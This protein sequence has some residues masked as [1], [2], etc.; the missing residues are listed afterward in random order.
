MIS[1][2][3]TARMCLLSTMAFIFLS[4]RPCIADEARSRPLRLPGLSILRADEGVPQPHGESRPVAKLVPHQSLAVPQQSQ[5]AD[6]PNVPMVTA[7]G[8]DMTR[9]VPG[10]TVGGFD[11]EG[12][13]ALG[14][15]LVK[16]S[17]VVTYSY[18]S[19]VQALSSN[20]RPDTA[21]VVSP[22]IEAFIPITRNGIRLDYSMLYR[23]YRNLNIS[24]N[25]DHTFNADSQFDLS[26]IVSLAVRDHFSMSSIDA[27]EFV[28]GREIVFSDS[29]FKRNEVSAQLLWSL[30]ENDSLAFTSTWNRV[31]FKEA[32]QHAEVPFYDYN[33]MSYA[34]TY[35]R[36]LSERFAVFGNGSYH[37]NSTDDPRNLADSRGFA[38]EGGIDG[39]LSPLVTGQ[40]SIGMQRDS[41]P[42]A[43]LANATALIFKGALA[44]EITERSQVSLS[45]SRTSNLSYFQQNAYFTSTGIVAAYGRELGRR[46]VTSLSASYQRN[47]YPMPLESGAGIP[48]ELVGR[49]SRG[50]SFVDFDFSLRYR[51]NDWLAMDARFGV[52]HRNSNVPEE[53][54]NCYRAGINFLIGNRGAST[55]RSPY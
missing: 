4:L 51:V 52:S 6:R 10:S 30:S 1:M 40:L 19:N 44:K 13:F 54:F 38:V 5:Q 50:D 25:F 24:Q 7:P 45:L 27:R 8:S 18:E 17:A 37:R 39:S 29:P 2:R 9:L 55:G 35:K 53:Q 26:P 49:T 23:D 14:S 11:Q 28:P 36:D 33:Q 42:G 48:V 16:P 20:Y 41:Y 3:A 47:G 12:A 31:F 46:L 21:L 32:T 15:V 34:G 22:T 43:P